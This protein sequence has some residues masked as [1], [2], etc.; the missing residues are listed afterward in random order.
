MQR[1]G[2]VKSM[3]VTNNSEP[4]AVESAFKK[5]EMLHGWKYRPTVLNLLKWKWFSIRSWTLKSSG[6]FSIFKT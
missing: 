3:D 5:Q 2:V 6:I 1:K 4:H